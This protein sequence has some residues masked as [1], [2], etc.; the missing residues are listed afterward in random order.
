MKLK[1]AALIAALSIAAGLMLTGAN[2]FAAATAPNYAC[3]ASSVGLLA[4]G[5]CP[6]NLVGPI[7]V[8]L[9]PACVNLGCCTLGDA[10]TVVQNIGNAILGIVGGLVLLFYVWGGFQML[11]SGSNITNVKNGKSSLQKATV[12][13]VIVFVAYIAMTTLVVSLQKIGNS[14]ASVALPAGGT[15]NFST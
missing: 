3:T 11:M 14:T 9:S 2:A 8:G 10:L 13:L 4:N 1:C 15:C 7:L 12:G 6:A 5:G